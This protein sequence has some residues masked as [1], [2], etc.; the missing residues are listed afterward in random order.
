M[1]A[2]GGTGL[3]GT[4]GVGMA[5]TGGTSGVGG[6]GGTG[7][8]MDEDAGTSTGGAGGA[9]G[10]GGTGGTQGPP[11]DGNQLAGCSSQTDCNMGTGCYNPAP[12]S[13]L[14]FC[15][16][17]CTMDSD[18]PTGGPA[19]TC[20]TATGVSTTRV[21]VISCTGTSD[22]SCPSGMSCV[23]TSAGIGPGGGTPTYRCLYDLP[24]GTG[25]EWDPCTATTECQSGLTC[26]GAINFGM[27][28]RHGT[29][30]NSCSMTSDCSTAPSSGSVTPSCVTNIGGNPSMICGLPCTGN[31]MGCPTGM[32]CQALGGAGSYCY[33]S[34]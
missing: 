14:G 3:A 2:T 21:C 12:N 28:M 24:S 29:C 20:P 25:A 26:V 15:S 5:G 4:G 19:Y 27:T 34:M 33:Q 6:A 17:T 16:K 11:M 9:G 10:A 32:M 31:T 1:A 23:Q 30:V 18:C 7:G 8:T 13:G 22:T